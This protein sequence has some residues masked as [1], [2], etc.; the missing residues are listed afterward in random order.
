MGSV[1][2][3]GAFLDNFSELLQERQGLQGV[4]VFTAPIADA[5]LLGP[6]HI[7]LGVEPIDDEYQYLTGT[8]QQR[9]DELYQVDCYCISAGAIPP[10]KTEP[11]VIKIVRD[12]TLAILEEIYDQLR[13]SNTTTLV[14]EGELGVGDARIIRL[15]MTQTINDEPFA[16]ICELRFTI[17]VKA[18]F[19]P[20]N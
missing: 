2:T 17:R 18:T 5:A 15:K 3:I 16:R 10:T 7:V 9:I 11:E 6:E 1:S 8:P 4:A 14:T 12:R 13:E 20:A 19:I